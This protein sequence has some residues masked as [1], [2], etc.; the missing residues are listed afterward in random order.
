MSQSEDLKRASRETA[1]RLRARGIQLDGRESADQLVAV[2]EA[3]ERF[4]EAVEMKG[5][6]LMVDEGSPD[7]PPQP[8]DPDFALPIRAG[9]ESIAAYLERLEKAIDRVHRH[10][11]RE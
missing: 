8:D 1:D 5:G 2:Q 9:H 6:D 7:H 10:R 3:V 4:E 11:P